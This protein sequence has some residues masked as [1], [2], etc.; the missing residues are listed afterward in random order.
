MNVNDAFPSSYIKAS[1]LG[2][3]RVLVTIDRVEMESLGRGNDKE[4]KP[5]L[6]FVGK[7]KGMVLNKTNTKK[8][9][10]IVGSWEDSD[11]IGQQIVIYATETEFGGETV[12]C[13]RI[14]SP[15]G[16]GTQPKAN[17][18]PKPSRLPAT[19]TEPVGDQTPITDDDVPF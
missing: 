16:N 4:T 2:D 15:N 6:Y 8:I 7:Q 13:V 19:I 9:H 17:W 10:D 14:L 5:V 18:T 11:W 3:K 12:S 1:D